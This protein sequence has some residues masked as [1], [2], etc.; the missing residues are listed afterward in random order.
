MSIQ[1]VKVSTKWPPFMAQCG[2]SFVTLQKGQEKV[3]VKTTGL[4]HNVIILANCWN[5]DQMSM[6]NGSIS[7]GVHKVT[8]IHCTMW[9]KFLCTTSASQ[10]TVEIMI[11]GQ[12]KTVQWVMGSTKLSVSEA[13]TVSITRSPPAYAGGQNITYHWIFVNLP[14]H[15]SWQIVSIC[16]SCKLTKYNLWMCIQ[17]NND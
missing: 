8:P 17:Q 13:Q 11:D 14:Y 4:V 1:W 5:H 16:L 12:R 10:L 2:K 9:E 15:D 7:Y 3:K 6:S